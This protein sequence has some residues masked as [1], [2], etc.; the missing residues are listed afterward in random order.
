MNGRKVEHSCYFFSCFFFSILFTLTSSFLFASR[1]FPSICMSIALFSLSYCLPLLGKLFHYSHCSL[2]FLLFYLVNL[3]IYSLSL[4]L[5]HS[6]TCTPYWFF[7]FI[8]FLYHF[9][10]FSILY[11][12][13]S[14]NF[15]STIYSLSIFILFF[16]LSTSIFSM[17][18]CFPKQCIF[19]NIERTFS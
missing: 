12:Y 5:I 15:S 10:F 16:F 1:L 7:L 19:W 14:F 18:V 11:L 13:I 9:F 8:F 17:F 3:S 4:L 6:F 2:S